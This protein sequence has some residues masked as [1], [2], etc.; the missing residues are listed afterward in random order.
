MSPPERPIAH[1]R[2]V[3]YPPLPPG[4]AVHPDLVDSDLEQSGT[5]EMYRHGLAWIAWRHRTG[6]IS[7]ST[8]REDRY[9]VTYFAEALG[10][11]RP[12]QVGESDMA[13]WRSTLTSRG[14]A[15]A[16]VRRYWRTAN[17]FLEWLVDEGKIR[18]NPARR[19]PSPKVP[20]AVHRNLRP[21]QATAL[22]DACIDNRERLIVALGFQLGMR[23][24]EIAKAQIGDF[25][26]VARTVHIVGKGGAERDVALT[27]EAVRA[28]TAYLADVRF[29]AGPLVRD[30]T[31]TRAISPGYI[32]EL[33]STIAYRAGVKQR[34][35]DGVATHSAR[36]TAGTDVAH[37][38]GN[39]VITRDF[40]GHANLATTDIYVGKVDI[41]AQREAIEGRRYA[42]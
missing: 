4:G 1:L 37:R 3:P 39:A 33:F 23:R 22:H 24:F 27:D 40:L 2:L 34:P 6:Q 36:H 17:A 7:D 31:H 5:P 20:K 32:G 15:P 26:F 35:H 29:H 28:I 30:V 14:L 12:N 19:I 13:R 8:A 9:I 21:D 42:S 16:T 11:R 38:S 25:D 10:Q 41:E 18:R